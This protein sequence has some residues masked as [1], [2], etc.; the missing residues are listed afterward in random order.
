MVNDNCK[1]FKILFWIVLVFLCLLLISGR[2]ATAASNEVIINTIR[3][4]ALTDH[5]I[6]IEQKEPKGFED[7]VTFTVVNRNWP[8]APIR[9]E[10]SDTCTLLDISNYR[11]LVPESITGLKGIQVQ[12]EN[13]RTLYTFQGPPE[14]TFMP[15]PSLK[16]LLWIMPDSPRLI[17]PEWGAV[18]PPE[19]LP[20]SGWDTGN[21]A[22]DV[23]LFIIEPDQYKTFRKNFLKLTGPVP[24]PPLYAFG[25]WNSRYHPYTEASALATIDTFRQ[26]Q[27]PLDMFVV[28]TDWR[29]GASHG[30]R[31]NE[32]L[33]PDMRR[34]IKRAHEKNIRLMANDHPEPQT[35]SALD[36]HELQYRWEGL[37]HLLK[38]G[39]DVWWYDRNWMTGLLEP[40]PGISKEVWGMR[41]YHD[42]TQAFHPN[43]RP[44]IMSNVDGIDN[45]IWNTPSH[46]ASHRFPV[47]WTGDQRSRWEDLEAGVANGVNSGIARLMP[48][49]NEDLGGHTGGNPE[50]E[51]YIRWVQF[52][53]FSP[54][55][56]LHCTRGL[57]RYPWDYGSQA[58]LI[59]SDYIRLRYRLLPLFYTAAREA[60]EH[61]SPLM[62][63]CDLE[64]PDQPESDRELQFLLGRDLLVAPIALGRTRDI[65]L[66]SD[67]LKTPDGKPGLTGSYFNNQNLEGDPVLMR[68]DTLINFV[69]G[70]RSPDAQIPDNHFS[71]RWIGKMGP[72]Q[73]TG[74]FHF[75]IISD[76]GVRLWIGD[77]LMVNAWRDQAPTDYPVILKVDSGKCYNIRIEFYEN[78]GGA[79][80]QLV[81][82]IDI[83]QRF[84]VWIPPG[85]WQDI[86]TGETFRGP[87]IQILNPVLWK[88]PLYVRRGGIIFSL[89]QMQNTS[90]NKWNRVVVDVYMPNS[91][92]SN[93]RIL[94]EDDG[95]SPAYQSGEFCKTAVTLSRLQ[96]SVHVQVSAMQGDFKG[97]LSKRDWI[98]RLH[99]PPSCDAENI[100]IPGIDQKNQIRVI[101]RKETDEKRM[102][103]PGRGSLPRPGEEAV[104]EIEL[105]DQNT[106]KAADLSFEL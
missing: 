46:P 58:E 7:R 81:Q 41:L 14:N 25:L 85:Q 13:G 96:D 9:K 55:M 24:M 31:I 44:V 88:C 74:L 52:G 30:Y 99:L 62:R 68:T 37:T 20:N 80:L 103:F 70:S 91:N 43:R 71:A 12:T 8:G 65:P 19:D 92:E 4:Q 39:I 2:Q 84:T 82:T 26:K 77:S 75:K 40:M 67:L 51:Q 89:P 63:R 95:I 72:F 38:L 79:H 48:Y 3:I 66:E 102:P 27:I 18:P 15:G 90:E 1:N 50:P 69:W 16:I 23:Y 34:F 104:L 53:A 42:I 36:P 59:T 73:E 54:V 22:Q 17:P 10:E 64:W 45:G 28:D 78:G 60:Y 106:R 98:I 47:W 83:P 49:V 29:V 101:T 94:Y 93:T 21:D 57:T 56:R 100:H 97:A 61:G 105:K 86:W 11:I 5:L 33:F 32:T 76:D 35:G 87:Q 6:R